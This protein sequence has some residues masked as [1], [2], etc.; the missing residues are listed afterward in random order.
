MKLLSLLEQ[1]TF[2]QGGHHFETSI[3]IYNINYIQS[4]ETE[5]IS[6]N[7]ICKYNIYTRIKYLYI[8]TCTYIK[9]EKIRMLS[10]IKT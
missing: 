8:E 7:T 2:I 10:C 9:S 5:C 3:Y 6:F 4:S 1:S